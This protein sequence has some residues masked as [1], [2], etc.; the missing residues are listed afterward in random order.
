MGFS[1]DGT[2]AEFVAVPESALVER[3]KNISFAGAAAM[4]LS[5]VTAWQSIVVVG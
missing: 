3:P 5:Y 1:K 2:H 4:G